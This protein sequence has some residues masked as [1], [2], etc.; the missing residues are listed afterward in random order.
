MLPF[1]GYC[2][3]LGFDGGRKWARLT[4]RHT[5]IQRS[6]H[7]DGEIRIHLA[8]DLHAISRRKMGLLDGVVSFCLS[9]I[10]SRGICAP[11]LLCKG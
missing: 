2:V 7:L 11:C 9:R 5:Q 8:N 6:E 3:H 1:E 4:N 10:C